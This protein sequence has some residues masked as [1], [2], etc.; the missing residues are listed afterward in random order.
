MNSDRTVLTDDMWERI[1][2]LLPGKTTDPGVTAADNRLFL[3]AVLWKAR[4]GAPWRD[5]PPRFGKWN[6]VYKRFRR[7]SCSGVFELVF[8]A[9]SET[10]D[11]EYEFI[12]GRI[13][14]A[15]PKDSE[16]EKGPAD[17]GPGVPGAD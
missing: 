11:F 3:E 8:D 5:L 1:Q 14:S 9:L 7:L 4:T 15:H 12:D 10:F 13:V 2:P 6:S 17:G 16:T